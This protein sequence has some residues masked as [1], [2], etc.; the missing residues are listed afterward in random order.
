MT[1]CIAAITAEMKIVACTDLKLSTALTSAESAVKFNPLNGE[2]YAMVAGDQARL[3]PMI[4]SI[5]EGLQGRINDL[6]VVEHVCGAAFRKQKAEFAAHKHLS[7]FGLTMKEFLN[8]G[9]KKLDQAAYFSLCDAIRNTRLGCA[10]LVSGFDAAGEP[11]I[12]DVSDDECCGNR[13]NPGY[14]AIGSGG[15]LALVSL[16]LREHSRREALAETIYN[17]CVAKFVAETEGAVGVRTHLFVLGRDGP[18]NTDVSLV[19][20]VR[21]AWETDEKPKAPDEDVLRSIESMVGV[22]R[23]PVSTHEYKSI[24]RA[25]RGINRMLDEEK[26]RLRKKKR[27]DKPPSVALHKRKE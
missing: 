19:S 3:E 6:P 22:A 11:H 8:I 12:F 21:E 7:G 14:W 24:L 9:K 1:V 26:N 17:V 13:D 18:I 23:H 16:L 25:T 5:R 2:W 15:R 4:R 10:L 27:G 20:G